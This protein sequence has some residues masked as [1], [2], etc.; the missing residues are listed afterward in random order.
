MSNSITEEIA[1][2]SQNIDGF[3]FICRTCKHYKGGCGCG[4]NVFI[5]FE[6]ANTIECSFWSRGIKCPHCERNH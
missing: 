4:M 1:R 2:Q 3:S 6:G 5:A